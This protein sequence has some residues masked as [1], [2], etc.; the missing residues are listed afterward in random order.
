MERKEEE[1]S[2][3][4]KVNLEEINIE[5]HIG[6]ATAVVLKFRNERNI[7]IE[8]NELISLGMEGLMEA[9]RCYKKGDAEFRTYAWK[10]VRGMVK[11]WVAK[12]IRRKNL[13]PMVSLENIPAWQRPSVTEK[14]EIEQILINKDLVKH[15]LGSLKFE[16]SYVLERYYLHDISL[17]QIGSELGFSE[18]RASQILAIGL[19]KAK[20]Y[21]TK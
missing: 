10:R 20:K 14:D 7:P 1:Q 13:A 11:D 6:W 18:S 2:F 8:Y 9:A 15:V 4:E 5:D 12:N 21:K 17:S 19:E 16:E 3:V